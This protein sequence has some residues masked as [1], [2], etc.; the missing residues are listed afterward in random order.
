MSI[1]DEK[2]KGYTMGAFDYLVKPFNKQQLLTVLDKFIVASSDQNKNVNGLK[3]LIVD[4]DDDSRMIIKKIARK[5]AKI[6]LI[7]NRFYN[8]IPLSFK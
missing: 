4:D 6:T 7:F 1:L 8:V 3:I 5:L 2:N